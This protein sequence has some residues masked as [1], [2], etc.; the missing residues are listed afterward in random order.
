M[1]LELLFKLPGQLMLVG[2][3][4]STGSSLFSFIYHHHH[5]Q[6]PFDG[7]VITTAMMMSLDHMTT[8]GSHTNIPAADRMNL[9]LVAVVV[10]VAL[11]CGIIPENILT[12]VFHVI[13]I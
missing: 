11:Y 6:Q 9:M 5:Q 3:L 13:S 10:V 4:S 1:A 7:L 2:K 12:R 8:N